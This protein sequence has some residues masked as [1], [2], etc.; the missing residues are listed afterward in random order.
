[1]H[2]PGELAED[3]IRLRGGRLEML[4]RLAVQEDVRPAAARVLVGRRLD[5]LDVVPVAVVLGE[6]AEPLVRIEEEV[7]VPAVRRPVDHDAANLV[8]DRLPLLALE[9][10]ARAE[11][12]LRLE[13]LPRLEFLEDVE[14]RVAR[15]EDAAAAP[16]DDGERL[17]E[18]AELDRGAALRAGQRRDSGRAHQPSMRRRFF[19]ASCS[20]ST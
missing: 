18:R 16:A 12:D 13:L 10:A 5:D 15:V 1:A 3:E 20:S 4:E 7:L 9:R 14:I 6:V 19:G 8:A 17:I 11:R 2:L